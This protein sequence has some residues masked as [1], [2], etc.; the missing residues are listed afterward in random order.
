MKGLG[1]VALSLRLE[2]RT[3]SGTEEDSATRQLQSALSESERGKA[4]LEK[5]LADLTAKFTTSQDQL[6]RTQLA[7]NDLQSQCQ[8]LTD[9]LETAHSEVQSL[10]NQL[11]SEKC[12]RKQWEEQARELQICAQAAKEARLFPN[13]QHAFEMRAQGVSMRDQNDY[14][15]AEVIALTQTI[16]RERKEAVQ[17]KGQLEATEAEVASLRYKVNRLKANNEHHKHSLVLLA[18]EDVEAERLRKVQKLA[19]PIRTRPTLLPPTS[20][21]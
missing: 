5:Y 15:L 3:I 8:I 4:R 11:N 9:L 12:K 16:D 7:Q 18:P 17:R 2:E 21:S 1:V 20:N 10:E 19:T 13:V 6:H 14:L